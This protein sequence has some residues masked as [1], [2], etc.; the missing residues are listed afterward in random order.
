M[1]RKRYYPSRNDLSSP[2]SLERALRTI[3]DTVYSI[4]D[5]AGGTSLDTGGSGEPELIE[6]EQTI[7]QQVTQV[8]TVLSA[9]LA[10]ALP[11][12]QTALQSGGS[13]PLDLS[14]LSGRTATKQLAAVEARTQFPQAATAGD[15]DLVQYGPKL[16]RYRMPS[17]SPPS[18]STIPPHPLSQSGRYVGVGRHD[19]SRRRIYHQPVSWVAALTSVGEPAPAISGTIGA[20]GD[21][22]PFTSAAEVDSDAGLYQRYGAVSYASKS[23]PI[24]YPLATNQAREVHF[25]THVTTPVAGMV[26]QRD[27]IGFHFTDHLGPPPFGALSPFNT[28]TPAVQLIAFRY[29]TAAGDTSWKCCSLG[30]VGTMQV[31]DSG[32]LG[33]ATQAQDLEFEIHLVSTSDGPATPVLQRVEFFINNMLVATHFG[34][35]ADPLPINSLG[36]IVNFRTLAAVAIAPRIGNVVIEW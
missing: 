21:Q 33:H 10:A 31:T 14:N 24:A 4:Q 2:Q 13:N 25:Y 28:D 7:L 32:V 11:A 29:S 30:T 12:V 8:N 35:V 23:Y 1:A 27:W 3:L 17:V 34:T 6:D 22:Q 16:M 9:D 36:W 20:S 5:S 26:T 15:G 19:Y 18:A